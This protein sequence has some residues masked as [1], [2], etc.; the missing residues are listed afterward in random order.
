M[1]GCVLDRSQ[2]PMSFVLASSAG[3][4]LLTGL[5]TAGQKIMS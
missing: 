5:T 3:S 2:S 4:S 1:G